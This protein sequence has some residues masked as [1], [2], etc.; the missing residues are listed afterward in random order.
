[1]TFDVALLKC[2]EV[3]KGWGMWEACLLSVTSKSGFPTAKENCLGNPPYEDWKLASRC[4]GLLFH[5]AIQRG[6]TDATP[7]NSRVGG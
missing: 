7:K 6:A 4:L 3:G 2:L 1:M 5:A